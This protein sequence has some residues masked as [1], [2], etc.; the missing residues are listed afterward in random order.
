M[1]ARGIPMIYY[2]DEI[3]MR[4]GGDPDN[5]RDFPARAFSAGGRTPDEQDLWRSVRTLAHLRQEKDCLRRG[6]LT[7]LMATDQV[8]AFTRQGRSCRAVVV[9]NNGASAAQ[10]ALPVEGFAAGP[11]KDSLG[12]ADAQFAG[13]ALQVNQPPRSASVYLAPAR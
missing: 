7:D 13:G 9:L 8:Y 6:A 4:G 12:I 3:G 5:R 2:G 1:T 10:V 11:V